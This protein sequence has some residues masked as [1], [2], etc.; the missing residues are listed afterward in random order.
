MKLLRRNELHSVINILF[1]NRDAKKEEISKAGNQIILVLYGSSKEEKS[2]NNYRFKMFCKG[3]S[4]NKRKLS[5][6]PPTEDA[7]K[8]HSLRA[9]LQ[10]QLWLKNHKPVEAYGWRQTSSGLQPI[11]MVQAAA[12]T[13]LLQLVSCKCTKD[14]SPNSACM[15]LPQTWAEVLNDVR[16]LQRW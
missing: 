12:P 3:A 15:R 9:Y 8:F 4:R 7:T 10:I 11:P 14:C 1:Y 6:L 13:T 5:S 16:K 2:L